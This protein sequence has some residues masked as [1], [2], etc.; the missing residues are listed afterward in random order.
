ME[1]YGRELLWM[2][3]ILSCFIIYNDG[4]TKYY[5][6]QNK[7]GWDFNYER[8]RGE[9]INKWWNLYDSQKCSYV[10]TRKIFDKQP[11]SRKSFIAMIFGLSA[12]V[13]FRTN[14]KATKKNPTSG[15]SFRLTNHETRKTPWY[16][17]IKNNQRVT[18]K[19]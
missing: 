18:T 11:K 10:G 6:Y 12:F 17:I 13:T 2:L 3:A 7:D 8:Y 1:K 19:D 5:H 16:A 15:A 9:T 4:H 14:R